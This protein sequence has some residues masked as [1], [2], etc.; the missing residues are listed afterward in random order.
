MEGVMYVFH[1]DDV[2]TKVCMQGHWIAE[3]TTCLRAAANE[4]P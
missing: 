1:Y 3:L 4:M 2:D